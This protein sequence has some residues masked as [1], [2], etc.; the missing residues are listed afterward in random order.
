MYIVVVD[1]EIAPGAGEAFLA[2][3]LENARQ[4]LLYEPGCRQFD[5]CVD[6]ERPERVFLYEVYEDRAAFDAHMA[7]AH[8]RAFDAKSRNIWIGKSVQMLAR[9]NGAMQQMSN[10]A[11]PGIPSRGLRT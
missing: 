1:F 5:V 3:I 10:L 2:L 4:S 6:P 11:T 9:L 7:S 8:Y